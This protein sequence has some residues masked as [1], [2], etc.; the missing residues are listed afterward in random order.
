MKKLMNTPQGMLD[1]ALAGFAAANADIVRLEPAARTVLRRQRKPQGRVALVSGGGSGH[2]PMHVGYVGRGMLDAACAGQIFTSPTP[3]QIVAAMNAVDGGAGV[4]LIVKNYA[5]DVMNFEMAGD[6][7]GGHTAMVL[8]DDDVALIGHSAARGQGNRGVAGTVIVEKIAGA[9]A[10]RGASLDDCVA[11]ANRAN[12]ATGTMAAAL[13]GGTL[14]A[15]GT[16]TFLLDE[17]E[18]EL[19]VGIHGEPGRERVPMPSADALAATFLDS[20]LA[21]L[22]PDRDAALLLMCNGLGATPPIEL[23]TFYHAARKRLEQL[24]HR[25]ERSLVGSFCTALDMAGASLTVTVL[26]RE[27]LSLWDDPVETP[28]LRRG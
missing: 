17:G 6:L 11:V 20:I 2:E 23:F 15:A 18:I 21:K 9:A 1:E 14:P 3:D 10:E 19:G 26:D 4:L 16:P 22:A 28:A 24:G 12:A 25:V 5:G 13:R 27:L 8:V 7:R